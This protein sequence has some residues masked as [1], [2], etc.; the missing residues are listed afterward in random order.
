MLFR[1]LT[2]TLSPQRGARGYL[3]ILLPLFIVLLATSCVRPP[4]RSINQALLRTNT[5]QLSDDLDQQSLILGLES[6]I[7]GLKKRSNSEMTFGER[8]ILRSDY[9]KSLQY[10]LEKA[11][12]PSDKKDFLAAVN[13]DF[14]FYGIYGGKNF[15]EALVTSYFEPE[16]PGSL[17]K[18]AEL[19]A[20]LYALPKDMIDIELKLFDRCAQCPTRLPGRLIKKDAKNL[21]VPYYTRAEIQQKNPLAPESILCWVKP[22]DAFFLQIQGSGTIL[23]TDGTK[24]RLGYHG[25]NG[26]RYVGIGGHLSALAKS[27][28]LPPPQQN[29]QSIENILEAMPEK[30]MHEYLNKNPSYVFFRKIEGRP[31]T[32]FGTEVIDGRTIATDARYFPKG[33]LGFLIFDRPVFSDEHQA[34]PTRWEKTA[35]FILDQDTGGAIKGGEHIDLF[36]GKGKS[37]KQHAG[38]MKVSGQLWYLVPKDSLLARI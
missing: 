1:P 23:L 26:H 25:Q 12:L 2:L 3:A 7:A 15:G 4:L 11:K 24:L 8:K 9:I 28:G 35:R 29:L 14:D 37:A 33:A 20:P 6:Q 18:T 17:T 32:S 16:I 19:C 21:I 36:W 10:L 5:P 30:Q 27:Q 31:I 34:L 13:D 22:I 38:V